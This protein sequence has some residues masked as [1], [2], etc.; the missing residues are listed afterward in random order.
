MID[1]LTATD[2]RKALV[3]D[4]RYVTIYA[5]VLANEEARALLR[6][7]EDLELA[8]QVVVDASLPTRIQNIADRLDIVIN[9]VHRVTD[10][11]DLVS[12]IEEVFSRASTLRAAVKA[13]LQDPSD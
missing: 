2:G 5:A 12:P 8:A 4:S 1:D 11:R 3:K 9:D 10:G 13:K 6:K 7:H